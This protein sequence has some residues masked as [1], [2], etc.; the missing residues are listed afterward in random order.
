[1]L[2]RGLY[3]RAAVPARMHFAPGAAPGFCQ[4]GGM[5]VPAG[6]PAARSRAC[7]SCAAARSGAGPTRTRKSLR[8]EAPLSE[9]DAR[10]PRV[11]TWP[12]SRS[13]FSRLANTPSCTIQPLLEDWVGL[14][15]VPFA[16]CTPGVTT[17]WAAVELAP[18]EPLEEAARAG[19]ASAA[20]SGNDD[21]VLGVIPGEES[22]EAESP[23]AAAGASLVCSVRLPA[24]AATGEDT[25]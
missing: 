8:P 23:W 17:A 3:K 12:A 9:T 18:R 22:A 19:A 6:R 24:E 7:I 10:S 4:E 25:S 16:A 20:C 21:P 14:P 5:R 13:A 1:M 2:R 15:R 11:R